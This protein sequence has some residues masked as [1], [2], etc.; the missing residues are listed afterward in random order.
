MPSHLPYPNESRLEKSSLRLVMLFF[1]YPVAAFADKQKFATELVG[2][3]HRQHLEV[4]SR[5]GFTMHARRKRN[6]C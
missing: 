5:Y 2:V 3:L 4:N 6:D 1:P